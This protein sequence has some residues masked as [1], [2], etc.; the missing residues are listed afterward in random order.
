MNQLVVLTILLVLSGSLNAGLG[1]WI[2]V[3]V[4]TSASRFQRLSAAAAVVAG[5]FSM[6]VMV[7]QTYR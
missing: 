4:Y 3:T 7:V 1:T 5:V 2:V 6:M